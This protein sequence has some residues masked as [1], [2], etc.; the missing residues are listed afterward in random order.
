MDRESRQCQ[1]TWRLIFC[2][3]RMD[4]DSPVVSLATVMITWWFGIRIEYP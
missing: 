2:W 4:K 3:F 1:V